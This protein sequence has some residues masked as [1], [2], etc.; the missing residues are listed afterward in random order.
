M[1]PYYSLVADG[2][3][4]RSGISRLLCLQLNVAMDNVK[5]WRFLSWNIRGLNAQ[6]K[7]DHIRNKI[8]ESSCQ[9]MCL[10]E[11]RRTILIIII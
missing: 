5:N 1:L 2:L 8:N 7:W 6:G 11:T 9:I 3:N 4:W 10:Q